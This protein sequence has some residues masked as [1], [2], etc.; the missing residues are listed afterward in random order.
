MYVCETCFNFLKSIYS[1]KQLKKIR[2]IGKDEDSG[3]QCLSSY[4]KKLVDSFKS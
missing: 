1:V 3:S 2:V 4:H